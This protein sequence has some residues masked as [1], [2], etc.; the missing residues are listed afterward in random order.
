MRNGRGNRA[1][2]AQSPHSE[3]SR[4]RDGCWVGAG[5]AGGVSTLEDKAEIES[6]AN[7]QKTFQS[8]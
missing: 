1:F 7:F 3:W 5:V 6:S 2:S 4:E 8:S